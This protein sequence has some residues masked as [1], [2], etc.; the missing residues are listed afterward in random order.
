MASDV[1]SVLGDRQR[2]AL[3]LLAKIG[4]I[5]WIQTTGF[6]SSIDGLQGCAIGIKLIELLL[7]FWCY[8]MRGRS[9]LRDRSFFSIILQ[10]YNRVFVI[11]NA[12]LISTRI[13]V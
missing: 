9:H 1:L 5:L 10:A 6:L 13:R 8:Q 4:L 2:W 3:L 7:C 11:L 12:V